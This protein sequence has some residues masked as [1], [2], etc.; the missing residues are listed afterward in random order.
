MKRCPLYLSKRTFVSAVSIL[1]RAKSGH[2]NLVD[3]LVGPNKQRNPKE[4]R[5]I[6]P[7][8]DTLNQSC[9]H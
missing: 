7:M 9:P 4:F 8:F 2:D 1:L 6:L 3:R 5:V